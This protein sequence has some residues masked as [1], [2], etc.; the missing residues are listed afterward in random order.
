M[1]KIGD[2]VE[3]RAHADE[4]PRRSQFL[5]GEPRGRIVNALLGFVTD[6]Y[7]TRVKGLECITITYL[8]PRMSEKYGAI[9]SVSLE[10][11]YVGIFLVSR[12]EAG[13]TGGT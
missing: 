9:P 11:P 4:H 2:L 10:H 7:I 13:N 3:D 12:P 1:F 6:K 8:N 5:R